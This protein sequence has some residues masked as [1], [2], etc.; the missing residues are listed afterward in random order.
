MQGRCHFRINR[1][2]NLFPHLQQ[3]HIDPPFAQSLHHFKSDKSP[4]DKRGVSYVTL[5][6]P[7]QD[8]IHVSKISQ[9]KD[10]LFL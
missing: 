4:P 7:P 9:R 1:S 10:T 8:S 3:G 6:N 5:L 2:H